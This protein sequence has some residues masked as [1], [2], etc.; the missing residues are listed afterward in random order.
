MMSNNFKYRDML[1]KI[2]SNR[3]LFSLA[4]FGMVALLFS[5]CTTYQYVPANDGIYATRAAEVETEEEPTT[6]KNSYY[7]QYFKTKSQTLEDIPEEDIIFTDVEAYTSTETIDGEG[8]IIYVEREYEEGYGGWG[9]NTDDI[10]VNIYGGSGWGPGWGAWGPAWGWGGYWG[11][12][13]G[14]WYR[15]WGWGG[16]GFGW[17]WGGIGWGYGGFYN[18]WYCGIYGGYWNAYRPYYGNVY[19]YAANYNRGRRSSDYGIGRSRY[20]RGRSTLTN[21]SNYS[22]SE[23][24]RRSSVRSTNRSSVRNRSAVRNTRPRSSVQNR[25]S[26][27]NSRP[28]SSV[29][30][31][32]PNSSVNRSRPRSSVNRSSR[33]SRSVNRSSSPRSRSSVRSGGSRGGSR[34]SSVRRGRG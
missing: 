29:N 33:P 23:I 14:G 20:D 16:W 3:N 7:Q 11:G 5:S 30:R 10:T 2:P 34:G 9:D 28:N 18:P 4:L 26:V 6:D 31:S 8:N 15:P 12:Y 19:G 17:G 21:R 25:S 27:R 22:R 1:T 13:W 32:R 24:G